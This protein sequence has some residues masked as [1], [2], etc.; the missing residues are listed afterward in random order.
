[1]IIALIFIITFTINFVYLPEI[2]SWFHPS[3]AHAKNNQEICEA[4]K[5]QEVS[6]TNVAPEKVI[7]LCKTYD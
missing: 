2:M 5:Y 7:E 3:V 4:L 6:I 1:M